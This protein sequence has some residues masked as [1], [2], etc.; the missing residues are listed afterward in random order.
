MGGSLPHGDTARIAPA[1]DASPKPQRLCGAPVAGA[2]YSP[3]DDEVYFLTPAQM[4][5]ALEEAKAADETIT[6]VIAEVDKAGEGKGDRA[7]LDEKRDAAG[8]KIKA[9]VHGVDPKK[10]LTEIHFLTGRRPGI[11]FVSRA[12]KDKW[13]APLLPENRAALRQKDRRALERKG[14]K[15]LEKKLRYRQRQ[16]ERQ[17]K[18][19]EPR[20]ERARQ[21]KEV[22]ERSWFER[23]EQGKAKRPLKLKPDAIKKNLA[24]A[25]IALRTEWRKDGSLFDWE[26]N[27]KLFE[28]QS[29][30][31]SWG[32]QA[33]RY[34]VGAS[35]GLVFDPAKMNFKMKGEAKASFALGEAE[36]VANYY[37][38]EKEGWKL[39]AHRPGL[40]VHLCSL[41]FAAT[42]KLQG[43]AGANAA[44]SAQV[45]IEVD[46][47]SGKYVPVGI[48]RLPKD[49]NQEPTRDGG[50][51]EA[52]AF[53]GFQGSCSLG[54]A[55]QWR[56]SATKNEWKKIATCEY[57]AG[58]AIGLGGELAFRVLYQAGKFII[59]A[60]LKLVVGGG[61]SGG[62]GF[63][64]DPRQIYEFVR[65]LY[66]ELRR[67][68]FGFLEWI[69]PEAF[70]R[71][72]QI[73]FYAFRESAAFTFDAIK[74]KAREIQA[75]WRQHCL[76]EDEAADLAQR[77]C[78]NPELLTFATPEARGRIVY[79]LT[80]PELL[81]NENTRAE[82]LVKVF[83]TI[84]SRR[85][86]QKTLRSVVPARGRWLG[87]TENPM[88]GSSANQ[89]ALAMLRI[90]KMITYS[91]RERYF[92]WIA[93]LPDT[94]QHLRENIPKP[95][96]SV[97]RW[98]ST[99]V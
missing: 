10:R 65:F 26:K 34:T 75:V 88:P 60:R 89:E 69:A 45:G 90:G 74:G 22:R 20:R 39:D 83:E 33:M 77:L 21:I 71:W 80:A 87:T 99:V 44:I 52:S 67:H 92:K 50:L 18:A 16:A 97:N 8:K 15:G 48:E 64:V 94:E 43:F 46:K 14:E 76:K 53:A 5:V 66:D 38:P 19:R 81:S 35:A 40:T 91:I 78:A 95:P 7:T 58:A 61:A 72:S 62:V 85:E 31:G 55:L 36:L 93:T 28:G 30:D 11:A 84:Q 3:E 12:E 57:S 86:W 17:E 73:V 54:G 96:E 41:R 79:H 56:S 9:M 49:P 24:Q 4:R 47:A 23:D 63:A 42:F 2:A 59:Y 70:E 1:G 37:L 51:L 13:R 27:G 25:E 68:D 29:Y 82:A 32:A 98:K 6:Q